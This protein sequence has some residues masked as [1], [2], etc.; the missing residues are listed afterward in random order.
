[1]PL[2]KDKY[3]QVIIYLCNKL[4]GGVRGKKKLA[5]L[6]YFVD[7]DFFGICCP[8]VFG[9]CEG[10]GENLG[11]HHHDSYLWLGE[12]CKPEILGYGGRGE[13]IDHRAGIHC[14]PILD[15]GPLIAEAGKCDVQS[16]L[17]G[18]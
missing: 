8:D 5:K 4:G 16:D 2:N 12:R 1:M 11:G 18:K 10:S 3:Q 17:S 15:A 13:R 14:L 9:S 6:L 7:F